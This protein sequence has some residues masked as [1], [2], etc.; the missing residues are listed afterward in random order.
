MNTETKLANKKRL[1][2]EYLCVVY[3][4]FRLT[5]IY[6]GGMGMAIGRTLHLN[7]YIEALAKN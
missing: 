3:I 4:D 2:R 5:N 7:A 6:L 1:F